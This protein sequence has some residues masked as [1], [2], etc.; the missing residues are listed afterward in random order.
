MKN[1]ALEII[2]I[3]HELAMAISNELKLEK[4][5]ESFMRVCLKRFQLRGIHLFLRQTESK[6]SILSPQSSDAPLRHYLS[7][8]YREKGNDWKESSLLENCIDHSPKEDDAVSFFED[9]HFFYLFRIPD[10]GILIFESRVK[11]GAELILPLPPVLKK[12]SGACAAS[13]AYEELQ[14]EVQSRREAERQVFHQAHHDSLTQLSNR[15]KLNKYLEATLQ[16]RESDQHIGV[17]FF[18]DLNQFKSI[19]DLMGHDVGDEILKIVGARLSSVARPGDLVAR[20]GGDE[21]VYV[22]SDLGFDTDEAHQKTQSIA[23]RIQD[24]LTQVYCVGGACYSIGCSIGYEVFPKSGAKGADIIRNADVAMYEAKY[25]K[26]DVCVKYSEQ[27]SYKLKS[28]NDYTRDLRDAIANEEFFLHY[29]PIV[30]QHG[31]IVAAEALLRWNRPGFGLVSPAEYIPVAE[32]SDLIHKIGDW[33]LQTLLKDVQALHEKG[34]PKGFSHFAINIS[35]KELNRI[36][37]VDR[38][39]LSLQRANIPASL[40]SVE[41]TENTL[42]SNIGQASETLGELRALGVSS[43]IDDFGTGYSSLAYLKKLPVSIIKLDRDFV[44][45]ID[46]DFDNQSI[47]KMVFTLGE[48]FGLDVVSEGIEREEELNCLLGLG[49]HC[50]QGYYFYRPIPFVELSKLLS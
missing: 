19:N 27:M 36:G 13:L 47:A 10:R 11:L 31:D 3:Q 25:D 32:E 9:E 37:F 41:I 29:Q 12:F 8:P 28:K 21:F 40:I 24:Q 5:V 48:N 42:I 50:F 46:S 49:A 45:H 35:G 17:L 1:R 7:L 4:T 15:R 23:S 43:A 20:F 6:Q 22:A 14:Y 18:I 38:F 26:T 16:Q 30:S 33:V 34:L 44:S 2:A 39:K